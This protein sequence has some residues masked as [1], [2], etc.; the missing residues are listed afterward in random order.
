MQVQLFPTARTRNRNHEV[1]PCIADQSFHLALIVALGWA[2]ELIGEQIVTLQLGE[3]TSALPLL[4]AQDLRY[5]EA[6]PLPDRPKLDR[7]L[8]EAGL[9]LTWDAGKSEY[10]APQAPVPAT[11]TSIHRF[12]TLVSPTLTSF[13]AP[14]ELPE[15]MEEAIDFERR[16]RRVVA[17]SGMAFGG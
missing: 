7:L 12:E 3:R 9:E 4:T 1:P 8:S 10:L 5:P 2:A 14:K 13:A 11:S 15:D 6:Q 17:G 16:L